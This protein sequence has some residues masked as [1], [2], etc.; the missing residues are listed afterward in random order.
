MPALLSKPVIWA[1]AAMQVTP[2]TEQRTM[3]GRDP[4]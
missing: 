4:L 2:V 3:N 1:K